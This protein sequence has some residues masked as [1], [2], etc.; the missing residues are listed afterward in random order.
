MNTLHRHATGVVRR[1]FLQVGFSGYL[2]MSLAGLLGRQATA[3]AVPRAKSMILVFL[4]G[5][6]SHID[7]F[8]MKP[9]APQGIRGEFKP[10]ATN[11]PGVSFSE[12]LPGLAGRAD[13]LAVV[14]SMSHSNLNHLNSTHLVLT[15]QARQGGVLRQDRNPRR[16]PVL[17]RGG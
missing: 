1:E 15:G 6:P 17:R 12:H 13:K 14:R 3:A 11:V 2:G 7:T 9:N 16:L 5:A 4:T 10:I 8:D